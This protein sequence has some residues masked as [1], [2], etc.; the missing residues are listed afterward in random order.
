MRVDNSAGSFSHVVADLKS[1]GTDLAVC[2]VLVAKTS[3]GFSKSWMYSRLIKHEA[4]L[5]VYSS[6]ENMRMIHFGFVDLPQR[7]L[8]DPLPV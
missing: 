6:W 1:S 5:T 2:L 8:L 3:K 7:L 4:E